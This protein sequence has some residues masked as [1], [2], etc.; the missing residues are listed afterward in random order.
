MSSATDVRP[1]SQQESKISIVGTLMFA[2]EPDDPLVVG[3]RQGLGELGYVEGH[4]LRIEFRT[5][6][7][8]SDRLARLAGELVYG[9][10][11]RQHSLRGRRSGHTFAEQIPVISRDRR[12]GYSPRVLFQQGLQQIGVV[13]KLVS[14]ARRISPFQHIGHILPCV[15]KT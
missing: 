1:Q 8:Q 9:V 15:A 12:T 14:S 10:G 5:A 2:A 13:V 11:T 4:N 3:L 6:K 7:G